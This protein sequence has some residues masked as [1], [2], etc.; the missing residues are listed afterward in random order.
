M[1]GLMSMRVYK[2]AIENLFDV[3]QPTIVYTYMIYSHR[4][5]FNNSN[6]TKRVQVMLQLL[7]KGLIEL[8][9]NVNHT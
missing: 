3:Y 4:S 1:Y 8:V 7:L 2:T 6:H 9:L 5:N